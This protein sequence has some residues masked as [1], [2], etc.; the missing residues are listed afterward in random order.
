MNSF[1][2]F[3]LH[4]TAIPANQRRYKRPE[5]TNPAHHYVQIVQAESCG[6]IALGVRLFCCRIGQTAGKWA[7]GLLWHRCSQR[8]STISGEFEGKIQVHVCYFAGDLRSK[9]VKTAC[10]F[11]LFT[12]TS[13]LQQD[14]STK[15][16]E[17]WKALL[18]V[19]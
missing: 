3:S 19:I 13:C 4:W 1:K 16:I 17:N 9:F 10:G 18:G 14:E 2:S 6:P 7:Q 5:K 12:M 8:C 11:A 15:W